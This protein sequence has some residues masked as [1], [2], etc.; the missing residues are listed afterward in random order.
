MILL[1]IYDKIRLLAG[2][3]PQSAHGVQLYNYCK[4]FLDLLGGDK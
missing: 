1:T 2:L 3:V 4:F